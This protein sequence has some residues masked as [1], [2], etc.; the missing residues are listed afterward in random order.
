MGIK[1]A[2]QR[3]EKAKENLE[4]AKEELEEVEETPKRGRTRGDP[5]VKL[6]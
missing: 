1:K 3:I 4:A 6:G 5:V 2:Q